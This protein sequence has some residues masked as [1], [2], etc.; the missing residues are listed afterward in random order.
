MR[1]IFGSGSV[2]VRFRVRIEMRFQWSPVV[3]GAF[4]KMG[5]RSINQ[6]E[7]KVLVVEL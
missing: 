6:M 2:Q 7:R 3:D 1:F 4:G 5:R